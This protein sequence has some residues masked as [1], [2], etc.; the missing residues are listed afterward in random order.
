MGE[1]RWRDRALSATTFATYVEKTW[2]PSK[3]LEMS[4]RQGY[5]SNQDRLHDG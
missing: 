3:H 4:T 5:R 1:G 2:F